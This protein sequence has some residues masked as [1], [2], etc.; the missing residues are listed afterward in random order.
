MQTINKV[1]VVLGALG[2]L[3][4]GVERER[5]RG[6]YARQ[7]GALAEVL[8]RRQAS[9]EVPGAEA[10]A[11]YLRALVIYADYRQLRHAGRVS[12]GEDGYLREA[13]AAAGYG[14]EGEIGMVVRGLRENLGVCLAMKVWDEGGPGL[15]AGGEPVIR[16]GPFAGD[17][18]AVR[19][20]LAGEL[21]PDLMNHPANF[22]LV[23]SLA[24][25]LMW[26]LVLEEESLRAVEE[27][28]AQGMLD[29]KVAQALRQRAESVRAAPR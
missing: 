17:T 22:A 6:E 14:S 7:V 19:R 1:L 26:P 3:F 15:W 16:A 2:G 20:R 18:L 4:Y 5:A 27:F 9:A 11:R 29:A 8:D 25:A 13:L 24:G 23:P 28:R 21:A 12:A 10:E